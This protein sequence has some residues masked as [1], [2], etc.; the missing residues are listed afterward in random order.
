MVVMLLERWWFWI[1]LASGRIAQREDHN[2][3]VMHRTFA[4]AHNNPGDDDE[5]EKD[6]ADEKI[7]SMLLNQTIQEPGHTRDIRNR[8]FHTIL[9]GLFVVPAATGNSYQ[10][11]SMLGISCVEYALGKQIS[12]AAARRNR[13]VPGSENQAGARRRLQAVTASPLV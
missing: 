5:T 4:T 7:L 9:R 12:Q 8:V 1:W 13:R 3:N 11:S 2:R 6:E 10:A